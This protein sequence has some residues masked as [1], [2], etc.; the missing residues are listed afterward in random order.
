ML[1]RQIEETTL[2]QIELHQRL[3]T[4][5]DSLSTPF[6]KLVLILFLMGYPPGEL[7]QMF[8]VSK[9]AIQFHLDQARKDAA[10]L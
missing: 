7:K 1:N 2:N 3:N 5:I 10:R 9:Q 8:S 6:S 4:L